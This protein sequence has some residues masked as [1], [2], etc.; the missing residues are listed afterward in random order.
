MDC[1][2]APW[3]VVSSLLPAWPKQADGRGVL[4]DVAVRSSTASYGSSEPGCLGM[5]CRLA[6]RPT[7][8]A[9]V[10]SNGGG[11]DGT[12][13]HILHA[14]A[15]DLYDRSRLDL[16]ESDNYLG[17]VHL[18]CIV[19]LLS[20]IAHM[21]TRWLLSVNATVDHVELLAHILTEVLKIR[22]GR[23]RPSESRRTR[24]NGLAG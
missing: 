17:F 15:E 8:P 16:S 6:I 20:H 23:R 18:G 3:S 21:F 1:T 13:A 7:R 14:L 19:I 2:A 22:A 10:D 5:T 12:F 4:G 9:I 11:S 24:G